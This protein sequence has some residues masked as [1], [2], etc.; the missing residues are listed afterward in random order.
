MKWAP[1]RNQDRQRN[2]ER[3][4]EWRRALR[5]MGTTVSNSISNVVC[6]RFPFLSLPF[7]VLSLLSFPSFLLLSSSF[8]SCSFL[9]LLFF[10][11]PS[12]SSIFFSF[13]LFLFG[14]W[15]LW[16]DRIK[17]CRQR[18]AGMKGATEEPPIDRRLATLAKICNP[19]MNARQRNKNSLSVHFYP[20]PA[21]SSLERS[22]KTKEEQPRWDPTDW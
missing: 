10:C 13:L 5:E 21:C 22:I 9:Y 2:A 12:P 20:L 14:Q 15:Q 18:M 19:K 4:N 6:L 3:V 11:F 1:T 16:N 8:P 7:L 17:I